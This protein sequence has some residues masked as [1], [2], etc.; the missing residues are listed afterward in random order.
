MARVDAVFPEWMEGAVEEQAAR[1]QAREHMDRPAHE[2]FKNAAAQVAKLKADE[3]SRSK[4]QAA[5]RMFRAVGD[6]DRGGRSR[7]DSA[8][9]Q[10]SDVGN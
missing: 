5:D 7:Q 10:A 8:P 4:R 1:E 9:G 6:R 2:L 3:R